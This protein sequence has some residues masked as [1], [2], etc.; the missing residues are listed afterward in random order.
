MKRNQ[1][2]MKTILKLEREIQQR[3]NDWVKA[4]GYICLAWEIPYFKTNT[5]T[6]GIIFYSLSP[7]L[8]LLFTKSTVFLIMYIKLAFLY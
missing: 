4:M 1:Q 3:E 6:A 5:V 7:Q 2:Y 8:F